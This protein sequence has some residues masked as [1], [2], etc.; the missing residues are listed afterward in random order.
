[1]SE[2]IPNKHNIVCRWM[3]DDKFLVNPDQQVWP[4]CYLSN[5][6]YKFRVMGKHN[7]SELIKK[8]VDD[9]VNPVM[10]SYYEHE[11]ELNLKNNSLKN[12]LNHKWFKKI[13]PESWD[14]DNPHRLCVLMCSRYLDE[15]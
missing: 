8:G 7:D 3:E 9:F 1:M 14:T 12:I 10:Q 6:G 4:C 13:L 2:N 5:Q 11:E 15:E